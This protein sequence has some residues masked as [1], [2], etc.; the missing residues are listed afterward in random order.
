MGTALEEPI[1][2]LMAATIVEQ[3]SKVH[4]SELLRNKTCDDDFAVSS[5]ALDTVPFMD[6]FGHDMEVSTL[7]NESHAKVFLVDKFLTETERLEMVARARPHLTTATV[8]EVGDN[9]AVSQ[10]RRSQAANVIPDWDNPDDVARKAFVRVFEVLDEFSDYGL[11]IVGQEPFSVIQYLPSQEYRPHCDGACD[12]TP[13]M[14][15][16]RVATM[17]I[18]CQTA[19][20]GGATTFTRANTHVVPKNGQAVLFLYRGEGDTRSAGD[21]MDSGLTEHS[22]CPIKEGEK[23]VATSWIRAGVS[24]EEPWT[25]FD[26]TGGRLAEY[27]K[28]KAELEADKKNKK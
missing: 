8:N 10:Y 28:I 6:S 27:G 2:T 1:S 21:T 25:T 26:P 12:G 11:D 13:H 23:F 16:G 24:R 17:L 9:N 18:Y 22:G 4:I 19:E 14:H 15:G 3:D 7:F 20:S 5:P